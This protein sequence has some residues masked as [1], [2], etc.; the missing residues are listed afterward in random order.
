MFYYKQMFA[1]YIYFI[2]L[3][4]QGHINISEEKGLLV[5]NV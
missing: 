3:N 5:E 2:Y 1:L 4:I